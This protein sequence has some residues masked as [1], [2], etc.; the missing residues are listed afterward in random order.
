MFVGEVTAY[1]FERH[2][3]SGPTPNEVAVTIVDRVIDLC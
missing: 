2:P 3:W 1:W